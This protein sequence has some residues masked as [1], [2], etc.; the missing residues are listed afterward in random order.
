MRNVV[1]IAVASLLWVLVAAAASVHA[2]SITGTVFDPDRRPLPDILV[3]IYH[4][5]G[6][7]ASRTKTSAVGSYA[8]R[9]LPDGNY[10]IRV[11]PLKTNYAAEERSVRLT[12]Y[13][14]RVE[15]G[16]EV[17]FTLRPKDAKSPSSAPASVF[18]QEVPSE[19]RRLY[20]TGIKQLAK[21]NG[22]Q[23]LDMLREAIEAFPTYYDALARLGMEYVLRNSY[24]SAKPVLA[25]AV[26]VNVRSYE[27]WFGL[28]L[29]HFQISDI[30]DAIDSF[31]M[32]ADINPSSVNAHL[33]HG[34]ALHSANKLT[35]AEAAYVQADTLGNGSNP[36]VNW[37]LARIYMDLGRNREAAK[38][39]EL[40]LKHKP[41]APKAGDVRKTI[42]RLKQEP[43]SNS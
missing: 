20:E 8:F 37:Q 6:K 13:S 38:Q 17:N 11:Q 28:G 3:E 18:V 27:G 7:Y 5:Q 26:E 22:Q 12:T 10:L 15:A 32:A 25:K 24:E 4:D 21:N 16:E 36:Q 34:I 9:G 43:R 1:T 14:Q 29:V 42:E 31:K 41:D 35:D 40:Y 39:L 33:R 2:G 23:G 19:A 30:E